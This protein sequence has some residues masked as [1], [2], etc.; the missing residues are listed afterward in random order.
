[1]DGAAVG[2]VFPLAFGDTFC[3]VPVVVDAAAGVALESAPGAPT[4]VAPAA[5]ARMASAA[6]RQGARTDDVGRR[7]GM[8][9]DPL[10]GVDGVGGDVT[11]RA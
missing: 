8:V 2:A 1:V 6:R 7:S 5:T 9:G 11:R 3:M 4:A 10:R